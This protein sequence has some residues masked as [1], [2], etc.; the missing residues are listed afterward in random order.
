MELGLHEFV[1][2][3][4]FA[5][6]GFLP[7]F[8]GEEKQMIVVLTVEIMNFGHIEQLFN[9]ILALHFFL[10]NLIQIFFSIF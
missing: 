1:K 3:A 9:L 8:L 2:N 5:A 10:I 6:A 7:V 4:V